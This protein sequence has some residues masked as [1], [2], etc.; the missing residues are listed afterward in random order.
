[1]KILQ[2]NCVYKEGSTGKILN[3]I[4]DVLRSHGHNV[5]TCYG[6]GK[7]Y[8]DNYSEKVCR[9]MEH[10]FNAL[11][12]RI[13]GIPFGGLFL[14]NFKIIKIIK[15]FQ[16]DVVHVHCANAS[17]MNVYFLLKYL[18]KENIKTVVTLHAE[19]FY[20]A[21]CAH[22]Y[23]CNKWKEKCHDCAVYKQVAGSWFFD[24]SKTSWEKMYD[25]FKG[26]KR[27][28]IIITAVSPWLAGR[29]KQ[30]TILKRFNIV[31][32]PNG[33]D[34]SVFHY[35]ENVSLINRGN[36][37]KIV[38]FVTPFFS[39][40]ETDLKGGRFLLSIADSL[41]E[42]KFIV[43]ASRTAKN[44][45]HMPS[46][47]QMWGQAK[48]QDELAQIYSEAD[49]T[50]LLS[51]RETFSMV[52]AESLCCG[53]SVVGFKAGGPE[54]IA[55]TEYC[56][57]VEYGQTQ[58]ITKALQH[59]INTENMIISKNSTSSYSKEFMAKEFVKVYETLI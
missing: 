31:Y 27:E 47:I 50:L 58:Q 12:S 55:L 1:M 40:E 39:H 17:T 59:D 18:A 46:N 51:R 37:I 45:R 5:F 54:S 4:G 48:T 24:R 42:Y 38:L 10:N 44:L 11:L 9:N 14:S 21:G 29:A 23:D 6:L 15:R 20:T 25:A 7:E 36:Y 41:P 53:T 28:N 33:V 8:Y 30:S 2:L 57:F 52:T 22:A 34:T 16:P 19:I 35:K 13:T 32:V 49:V 43:V 26:F 56:T 3:S